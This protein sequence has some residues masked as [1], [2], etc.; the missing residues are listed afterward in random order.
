MAEFAEVEVKSRAALRAWL[1]AHHA[2]AGTAWLVF[3]KKHTD[4][5]LSIDDIVSELLCWGWVDS[6][7]RGVDGDRT[8]IRISPRNPKS[9][10]SAVN[11]RKIAENRAAGLMQPAGEAMVKIA[12]ENGMWVFLDD[13]ERL[14]VP[15]DLAMAL[16]MH[17]PVWDAYPRNVKRGTLE[18]IKTAKKAET[19]ANRIA[20]VVEDAAKGLRPR[21]MR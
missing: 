17:R 7:T 5:Y 9:A 18:W 20:S 3:Y 15:D 1:A 8:S 6:V 12:E 21:N 14:E 10:W 4:H 16:G 2:K 11:K 13:V 19:R